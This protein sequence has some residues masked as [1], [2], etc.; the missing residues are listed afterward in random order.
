MVSAVNEDETVMVV[1]NSTTTSTE[2]STDKLEHVDSLL[3]VGSKRSCIR[4]V[5]LHEKDEVGRSSSTFL[6]LPEQDN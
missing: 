3:A 5:D 2:T 4:S 1:M 6:T